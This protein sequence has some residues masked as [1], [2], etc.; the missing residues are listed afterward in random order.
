MN[1]LA[2]RTRTHQSSVSVVVQRLVDH[3]LVCH[4]ISSAD[5]RRAQLSLSPRG[6][7]LLQ[8]SPRAA[9]DRIIESVE[10]MP[11]AQRRELARLL[12]R[13]VRGAGLSQDLPHMFFEGE[14]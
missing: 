6:R 14:K 1:A 12:D 9:Q 8:R 11:S 7:T 4:A 3:G 10:R 2:A 5:R 13:V